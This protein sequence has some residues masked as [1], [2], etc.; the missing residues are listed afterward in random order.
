MQT[1]HR[2]SIE[3]S[4]TWKSEYANHRDRY[5]AEK[6]DFWRDIFPGTMKEKLSALQ[7]GESAAESFGAGT[8]VPHHGNDKLIAFEQKAFDRTLQEGRE[9]TP[10]PGRF[11]PKGFAATAL[12]CFRC[13]IT[14]F[15]L[16]GMDDDTMVADIN[17][18]LARYP[19]N[20]EAR[21]IHKLGAIEEHGGLCN[22]IAE[23]VANQG[24]GMQIPSS[25]V[26]TGFYH[27][28]P[29]QRMNEGDDALF[30]AMPR[31]IG[32]LDST[33]MA[34]VQSIHAR[35]LSPGM[36]ILDLMSS[37]TSHLPE[38]PG[39]CFVTGLG[40]NAEELEANPALADFLVHDLN[41][42]PVLPFDDA[43]YD[44][45]ICTASIEYLIRP[46]EVLSEAARVTKPGGKI[47]ITFSDRWFPGKEIRPWS[48]MHHFERLGFVLD[49]YRKTGRFRDL[50]TESIRGLPRP[51]DDPHI[52]QTFTS[53]PI[54]AVWGDVGPA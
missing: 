23:L 37:C 43:Q 18:P 11:Y 2:A 33:A 20:L 34:Q 14:P 42:D 13:N 41:R 40:M 24:P 39:D 9:I 6:I 7:P 1:A 16:V 8:L 10:A 5:F 35:H 22:H 49:L 4:L 15:R 53:D 3:F 36:K 44:A 38:D 12:N 21:Y 26:K 28:Y 30:Y 45:V 52:R 29:F 50:N 48:D 25:G 46:I 17:H 51:F 54:F 19:L 47:I 31:L 27:P 32:H